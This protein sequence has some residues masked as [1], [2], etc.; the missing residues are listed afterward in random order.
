MVT[1]ANTEVV[2][3]HSLASAVAIRVIG[4]VVIV[5][6]IAVGAGGVTI[7]AL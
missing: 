3:V 7:I 2:S 6:A 5:V 4:V 1:Q